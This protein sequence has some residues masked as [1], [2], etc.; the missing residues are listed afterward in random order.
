MLPRTRRNLAQRR[1]SESTLQ[2]FPD[3]SANSCTAVRRVQPSVGA[4][5]P[6]TPV[7]CSLTR[8]HTRTAAFSHANYSMHSAS[9]QCRPRHVM[10][11]YKQI[12]PA[13]TWCEDSSQ[14][15]QLDRALPAGSRPCATILPVLL[16]T[17]NN[18]IQ[19]IDIE[20]ST[21]SVDVTQQCRQHNDA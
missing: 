16:L 8:I 18:A 15:R 3:Q 20:T 13:P 9:C 1:L 5:G 10:L 19:T 7:D 17:R 11:Q 14:T 4:H 6:Q 21:G 12:L 2:M